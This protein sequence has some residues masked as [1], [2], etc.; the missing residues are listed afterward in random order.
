MAI[1]PI[2]LSRSADISL[3]AI[4]E[5]LA[6]RFHADISSDCFRRYFR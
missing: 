2:T 4:R 1:T 3:R 5:M 6:S